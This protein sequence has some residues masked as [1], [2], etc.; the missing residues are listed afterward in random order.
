MTLLDLFKTRQGDLK[1][2][3]KKNQYIFSHIG[4]QLDNRDFQLQG[5]IKIRISNVTQL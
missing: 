2:K 4:L 3:I 5:K 1:K